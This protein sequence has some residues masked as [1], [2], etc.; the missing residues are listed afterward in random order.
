MSTRKQFFTWNVI[1]L[2]NSFAL[3]AL[4][5]VDGKFYT[6]PKVT[7]KNNERKVARGLLITN[8]SPLAQEIPGLQYSGSR[9][10]TWGSVTT[11]L[12]CSYAI[13]SSPST[14]WDRILAVDGPVISNSI[15]RAYI[16]Y[17]LKVV[18]E[19]LLIK[20]PC[21]WRQVTF[22]WHLVGLGTHVRAGHVL[23]Q[24]LSLSQSQSRK[25]C[26]PVCSVCSHCRGKGARVESILTVV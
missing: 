25:R 3:L 8:R 11:R 19:Y 10:R 16:L 22:T 15:D 24:T 17:S 6:D 14:I 7:G 9:K 2:W 20:I 26:S 5:V 23:S 21:L 13:I 18:I 1:K 12:H 4:D